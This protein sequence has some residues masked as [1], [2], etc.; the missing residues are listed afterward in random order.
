[1][2]LKLKPTLW[3]KSSKVLRVVVRPFAR[4]VLDGNAAST[5]KVT[6]NENQSGV[7]Q[8]N[9]GRDVPLAFSMFPNKSLLNESHLSRKSD[10]GDSCP[11]SELFI[12]TCT[13]TK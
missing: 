7:R 3:R 12:L 1:M 5:A 9:L 10:F 13:M 2:G 8:G 4:I 11:S 6:R